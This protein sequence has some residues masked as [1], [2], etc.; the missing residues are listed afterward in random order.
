MTSHETHVVTGAFGYSGKY[1]TMRLLES[2]H[3]VRTITGSPSRTN[4]FNSRVEACPFNFNNP[5][6]LEESLRGTSVLYNTYWIR[7]NHPDFTHSLAVDNTLKLFDAAKKAGIERIVH[8]SITNPS[9]DSHLEYF[10]GKARLERALIESGLSYAILRPTVLFGKEDILINNIA[11]FL[12]R[13]PVFGVFGDGNYRLQPIYVDDLARLAVEQGQKSEN[14]I[15]DAI[16]PETFT[17]RSMV[18]EIGNIIGKSKPIISI[19]PSSGYFIGMLIG[20]LAGD[21]TITRDEIEGL[22]SELLYTNSPPAG[23]TRLTE[24]VKENSSRL[25]V[26]YASELARRK[27]RTESYDKL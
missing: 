8:V 9:E 23:K 4:P 7:F 24:W 10:S 3:R 2:G 19:P 17:Y 1:I 12:R 15:I 22:M 21:V 13:F 5:D 16:G 6:K 27:N 11:W 18:E 25:G 14:C 20:K 26:Q